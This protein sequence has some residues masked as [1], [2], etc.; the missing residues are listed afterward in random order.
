MLST[1]I[2]GT[3]YALCRGTCGVHSLAALVL[4]QAM[5]IGYRVLTVRKVNTWTL[6]ERAYTVYR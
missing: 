4:D 3:N 2:R 6:F 5:Y 1:I